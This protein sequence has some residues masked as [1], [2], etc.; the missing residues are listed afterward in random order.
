MN[1]LYVG[2]SK[3]IEL[4]KG[5]FLF[6]DEV[7]EHPKVNVFDPLGDS[8]N[9]LRNIDKKKARESADV[10][11]TVSGQ[12]ENTLTVRNG[13]RALATTL[14]KAKRLDQVYVESAVKGVKEEV[15]GML[16][17]LLFTDCCGAFFVRKTTLPSRVKIRKCLPGSTVRN[18]GNSTLS[19]LACC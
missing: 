18:S 4:P 13:R 10:L 11:Y 2:F 3:E 8:F 9:P 1:K 14:A 5:S 17:E 16:G 6:I 15:E 12:G 19:F 7:P